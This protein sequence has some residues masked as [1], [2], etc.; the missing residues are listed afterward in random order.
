MIRLEMLKVLEELV[1]AAD[2]LAKASNNGM[3]DA[4]INS[5]RDA[6]AKFKQE[7]GDELVKARG[8]NGCEWNFDHRQTRSPCR[9]C[10]DNYSN[11]TREI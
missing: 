6:V 10:G 3:I 8:C 2:S 4:S 1:E 7:S 11:W 9:G 5:A